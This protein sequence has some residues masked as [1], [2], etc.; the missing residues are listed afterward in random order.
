MYNN[1]LKPR[2]RFEPT[3]LSQDPAF[4]EAMK[5]FGEQEQARKAADWAALMCLKINL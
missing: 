1:A 3:A 5:M 4:V 2:M